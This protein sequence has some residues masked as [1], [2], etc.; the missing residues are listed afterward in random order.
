[1][2]S[3]DRMIAY[4]QPARAATVTSAVLKAPYGGRQYGVVWRPVKPAIVLS[5]TRS[6]DVAKAAD[7]P[8]AGQ[9]APP[10]PSRRLQW[11]W[12]WFPSSN[13]SGWAR[14]SA[15]TWRPMVVVAAARSARPSR[16]RA[17]ARVSE[18]RH[19]RC[20]TAAHVEGERDLA[21]RSGHRADDATRQLEENARAGWGP[22]SSRIRNEAE[23]ASGTASVRSPLRASRSATM[24]DTTTRAI[25]PDCLAM[26]CSRRRPRT[27]RA[28]EDD[29]RRNC[30]RQG[31]SVG[32]SACRRLEPAAPGRDGGQ[33]PGRGRVSD[34]DRRWRWR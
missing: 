28:R 12:V 3:V 13:S 23:W 17:R 25:P 8:D 10:P 31:S 24:A 22:A 5:A 9:A 14:I 6:S 18:D 30:R 20:Q 33:H 29:A 34:N 15:M 16:R 32:G 2:V 1:M 19:R 21:R 4:G 7:G 26:T 27:T 11:C